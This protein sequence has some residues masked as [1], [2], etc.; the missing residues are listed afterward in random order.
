MDWKN[1]TVMMEKVNYLSDLVSAIERRRGRN[2]CFYSYT[3]ESE[4]QRP[5]LWANGDRNRCH[6]ITQWESWDEARLT[7]L[8]LR[9]ID[10]G[11]DYDDVA[12]REILVG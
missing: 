6:C 7:L 3:L 12:L 8:A 11:F 2:E 5:V 4:Q 10:R 9:S 1:R